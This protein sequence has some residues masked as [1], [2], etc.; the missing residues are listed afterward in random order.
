MKY[1][2]VFAFCLMLAFY[3]SC[4]Q[5]QNG[6]A[7]EDVKPRT[8]NY[9]ESQLRE[10]DTAKVPISMVRNVKRARNGDI[11]VASYLGVFR[12]NGSSFTNI[13]RAISSAPFA[14]FWDVLEDSKG[15]LW[16]GT[17]DSGVYYYNGQSYQH[18]TTKDG[19]GSNMA[20][21]IYEDRAGNIW[22][23]TGGGASRYD[24]KSFRNFTMKD[25]LPS[26]DINTFMEDKTG[27]L[28]I[29]TR[30]DA[31]Y[32]DGK[33]FTV[34]RNKNG[35]AYHNVWAIIEDSKG[36]IWFGGSIVKDRKGSTLYLDAGIWRYDGRTITKVSNRTVFAMIADKKGNIWTTGEAN[37]FG[38]GTW[39]LLR[40]EE[41]HLYGKEP[42]VTE[43]MSIENMLCGM[44]EAN[45]GS[46][47]FGSGAGV[48]RYDGKTITDFKTATD[49]K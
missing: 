42:V 12:Y 37:P 49:N 32:Y 44:V 2:C 33:T 19:L 9:S 22:L 30:G 5:K 7:K 20:L 24:G 47:W 14:S 36:H 10:A 11:L 31:C 43:I 21:H 16:F 3:S 48:Y 23:G 39:K 27:K 46:I 8:A 4:V 38:P 13:S 25:G 17:K 6:N 28:W 35:Q 26:N 29:G 15:N 1:T 34:L 41:K 40:Y 18:F 45:D